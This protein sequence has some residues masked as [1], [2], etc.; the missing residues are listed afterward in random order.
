VSLLKAIRGVALIVVAE[1]TL[2]EI[3]AWVLEFEEEDEGGKEIQEDRVVCTS[4]DRAEEKED[5]ATSPTSLL[6]NISRFFCI[7]L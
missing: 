7:S 5:E 4:K 1:S 6:F 3:V 2:A